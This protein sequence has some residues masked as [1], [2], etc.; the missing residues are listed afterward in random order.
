MPTKAGFAGRL[1]YVRWLRSRGRVKLETD[2]EFA[3]AMGVNYPWFAKWKTRTEAP[4][5]RTETGAMA[6]ALRPYGVTPD[7][8]FDAKGS[9]PEPALWTI[10]LNGP[11]ATPA[12]GE[13]I[14]DP[15]GK[16]KPEERQD[17]PTPRVSRKGRATG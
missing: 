11:V 12:V 15:R 1:A 6:E 2:R 17:R 4:D 16:G 10:W 8:L 7:W 3:A 9:P 13:L 14:P 5:G